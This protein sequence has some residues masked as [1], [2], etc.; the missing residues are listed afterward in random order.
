MLEKWVSYIMFSGWNFKG[1]RLDEDMFKIILNDINN[2][3][4]V[5][6]Y[7]T[8]ESILVLTRGRQTALR[9]D[10]SGS[11]NSWHVFYPISMYPPFNYTQI[12]KIK[13]LI[14]SARKV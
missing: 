5:L 6:T 11:Y 12:T 14:K 4:N 13:K 8:K 10:V 3:K 2:P 1:P 7:Y 9:I